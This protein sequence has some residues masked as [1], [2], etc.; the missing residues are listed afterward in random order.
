MTKSILEN[1]DPKQL[2]ENLRSSC[3]RQD[4]RWKKL[5]PFRDAGWKTYQADVYRELAGNR[6]SVDYKNGKFNLFFFGIGKQI[7]FRSANE[8]LEYVDE[9]EKQL[10]GKFGNPA[11][12]Q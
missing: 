9:V 8:A 2:A 10:S 12:I 4:E 6:L 5:S 11:R 7:S 3:E 1:P